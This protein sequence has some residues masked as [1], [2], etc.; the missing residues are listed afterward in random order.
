MASS[1]TE[2]Y[3]FN[4]YLDYD[5]HS[6]KPL[7][8]VFVAEWSSFIEDTFLQCIHATPAKSKNCN[9]GLY[10]GSLGLVYASYYLLKHGHCKK[11]ET[12][13][14]DYVQDILR[15]NQAYFEK[16]EDITDKVEFLT[17][18]GGLSIA[19]CIAAKLAGDEVR[20]YKYA[21]L[22]AENSK[23]CEHLNFLKNGSDEIFVGRAGYLWY[24]LLS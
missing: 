8:S 11:N 12:Y 23:I 16:F 17:G 22:Y 10:C 5:L 3:F 7:S 1:I 15:F 2:R 13:I 19:S 14:K 20:L 4:P 24:I 6:E 18:K 21:Q 9:G